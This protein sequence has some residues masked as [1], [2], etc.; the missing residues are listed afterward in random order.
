MRGCLITELA[1]SL[2]LADS[3]WQSP[4]GKGQG[5]RGKEQGARGKE[6]GARSKE[7]GARS[8]PERSED[9]AKCTAFAAGEQGDCLEAEFAGMIVATSEKLELL[10]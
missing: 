10:I 9:P 7:Q 5:A 4:V 3:S 1:D 8:K 2:Q 6:Q